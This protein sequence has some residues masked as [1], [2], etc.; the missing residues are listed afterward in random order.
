[1]AQRLQL[2][3]SPTGRGVGVRETKHMRVKIVARFGH[4]SDCSDSLLAVPA[5]QAVREPRCTL[6]E[7]DADGG[8][9]TEL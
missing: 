5:F 2:A 6:G 7:Y 4:L 3:P 1:M 8:T 9:F